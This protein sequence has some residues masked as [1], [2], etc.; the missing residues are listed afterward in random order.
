MGRPGETIN[1]TMFAAAIGIDRAV[2]VYIGRFIE[3]DDRPT[4]VPSQGGGQPGRC[5]IQAAPAIVDPF[6]FVHLV[7]AGLVTDG[8]STPPAHG[9]HAA[10]CIGGDPVYHDQHTLRLGRP[11]SRTKQKHFLE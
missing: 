10:G 8:P 4:A 9:M 11:E 3:A 7:A 6:R 1:A 5:G 2:K